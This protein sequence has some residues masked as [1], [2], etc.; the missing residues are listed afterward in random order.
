MMWSHIADALLVVFALVMAVSGAL[1]TTDAIRQAR[2]KSEARRLL[3]DYCA[4]PT[5][6]LRPLDD[7]TLGGL[8]ADV[9]A[10]D[11]ATPI[12]DDLAVEYL[13]RDLDAWGNR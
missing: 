1:L 12:H 6:T 4:D 10:S 2:R 9:T 3:A 7:S 13:R 8:V 11:Y 5:K